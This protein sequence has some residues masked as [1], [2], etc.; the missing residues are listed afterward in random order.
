MTDVLTQQGRFEEPLTDF[1]ARLQ[2]A[3]QKIPAHK[4]HSAKVR[5]QGW[6]DDQP[7]LAVSYDEKARPNLRVVA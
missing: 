5:M 6:Y 1:I 7:M 2:E 3:V 4:R